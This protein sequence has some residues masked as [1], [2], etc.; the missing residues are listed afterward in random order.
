MQSVTKL[1]KK[2]LILT[3]LN[4][5]NCDKNIKKKNATKLKKTQ[6][7]TKRKNSHFDETLKLWQN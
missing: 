3:K 2:T 5:S 6:I 4:N 1:K 7:M